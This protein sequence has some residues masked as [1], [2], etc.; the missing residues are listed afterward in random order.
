MPVL[1]SCPCCLARAP[2][3]SQLD[4]FRAPSGA[5]V[6]ALLSLSTQ[7]PEL[8]SYSQN[9]AVFSLSSEAIHGSL[10]LIKFLRSALE[11][12][13]NLASSACADSDPTRLQPQ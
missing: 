6:S 2:L 4:H 9:P 13:L 10:L 5:P 8:A 11:T 7:L 1:S 3:I 12:F